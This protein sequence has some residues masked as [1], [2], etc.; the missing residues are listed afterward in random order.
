MAVHAPGDDPPPNAIDPGMWARLM[1]YASGLSPIG[2]ANAAEAPQPGGFQGPGTQAQSGGYPVNQAGQPQYAF[3]HIREA[4]ASG[5]GDTNTPAILPHLTGNGPNVQGR[6]ILPYTDPNTREL[7]KAASIPTDLPPAG[8]AAPSRPS[9][10]GS[11]A[12]FPVLGVGGFP[13][14]YGAPGQQPPELIPPGATPATTVAN[15]PLPPPR[16]AGLGAT[17]DPRMRGEVPPAVA[18]G[19]GTFDRPNQN[20][21][22]GGGMMGGALAGGRGGGGPSQM[23]MLDLSGIFRGGQP[24]APAAAAPAQP[25]TKIDVGKIPADARAEVPPV[26]RSKAPWGYGPYQKGKGT[27]PFTQ[28]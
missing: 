1:G 2:S 28:Y 6:P 10:I 24:A 3:P 19:W 21:G 17:I 8:P 23:G 20:P 25:R 7:A 5:P 11:D 9:G 15:A 26:K 12:N 27:G 14:T 16:P 13:T 22:L 18:P 4:L